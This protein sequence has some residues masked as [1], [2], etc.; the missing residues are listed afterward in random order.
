MRVAVKVDM[1]D[2]SFILC[3]GTGLRR[4]DWAESIQVNEKSVAYLKKLV[5]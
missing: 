4:I 2:L 5:E 1:N 3:D